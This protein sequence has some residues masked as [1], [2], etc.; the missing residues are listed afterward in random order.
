MS[1]PTFW[2]SILYCVPKNHLSLVLGKLVRIRLPKPFSTWLVR[3][4]A[5]GVG[6]N[7]SECT[8]PIEEYRS[9]GD[10]FVRDLRPESRPIAK[11]MVSP[12]DGTLRFAGPIVGRELV[13][14]K[15]KNYSLDKFLGLVAGEEVGNLSFYFN[16]YLSPRDYH[17]V[18]SPIDGTVVEVVHLPGKLWPVN[19]WSMQ[20]IDGLFV[21]NE[22]VVVHLA[23][24]IGKV[25]VVFVG[26]TNVGR[27]EIPWIPLVTNASPWFGQKPGARIVHR[28]GA[29]LEI[30]KGDRLGT[31]HMGS[32]VVVLTEKA[33]LKLASELTAPTAVKFGQ[34]IA[35]I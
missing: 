17:H 2:W 32:S 18:H 1:A 21:Q 10:F 23:T 30:K 25:V 6:A 13:Q 27:I 19:D 29:P 35:E 12:V 9:I 16:L 14:V 34:T 26:A 8:K 7:L 15:G 31:F 28:T 24:A 5:R 22:R 3:A 4:F 20:T 33:D 11:G